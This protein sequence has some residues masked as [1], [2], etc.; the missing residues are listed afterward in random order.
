LITRIGVLGQHVLPTYRTH[1]GWQGWR[2]RCPETLRN[3]GLKPPDSWFELIDTN[4]HV[5]SNHSGDELRS[6]RHGKAEMNS[7]R[8]DMAKRI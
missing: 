2:H 1:V 3:Y 4:N 5:F 6:M 8:R 7:A